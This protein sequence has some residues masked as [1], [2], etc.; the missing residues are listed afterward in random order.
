MTVVLCDKYLSLHL[1]R[2][3]RALLALMW[4]AVIAIMNPTTVLASSRLKTDIV[5]MRNGDKITCEIRSLQQGQLTVKPDY[6]NAT[7]ALDWAKIDH[8]ESTQ[9]FVVS[10]PQGILHPGSLI[11]EPRTGAVTIAGDT[12]KTLSQNDVVEI[13]PLGQTFLRKFRGSIDLGLSIARSN[14]QKNLSLQTDL[15]YQSVKDIFS[16]D[17]SYQFTTQQQTN[18]T[19][20]ATVKSELF[21]QLK[22]SNWY[23]GGLAN[24]LASSEQQIDLRSTLGLGLTKRQ[25]FTNRTNLNVI[26]GMVYTVERDAKDAI[27]TA[28]TS[29]LDGAL[30]VQYSTFRFDSTTFDTTLWLYPSITSPGRLRL[31]LN[32]DVYYKFLG[33]FYVRMSFY[34]NYDNQPVVGAPTNNLGLSS[35]VGWSFR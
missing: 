1:S 17:S 31:T 13:E 35:S 34:D 8:I 11:G 15:T 26:G 9:Q 22:R 10:D 7:I 4:C 21:R 32:Q 29:S 30:A 14:S 20:E 16:A 3:I 6:T 27:S 5:Y 23:A 2:T 24:F 12:S 33:D 25:I 19:N 18:N 28:R